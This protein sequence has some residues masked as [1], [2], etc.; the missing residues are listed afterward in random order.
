MEFSPC[1]AELTTSIAVA[2]FFRLSPSTLALLN[3]LIKAV[4]TPIAAV[5]AAIIP[6]LKINQPNIL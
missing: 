3:A 2:A 6:I 1:A 5:T 4:I